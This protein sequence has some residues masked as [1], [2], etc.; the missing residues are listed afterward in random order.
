MTVFV[1]TNGISEALAILKPLPEKLEK[2]AI[3]L[4]SQI[5][6]DDAHRGAGRHNKTGALVQSLFN[7]TIPNGREVGHDPKRAPHAIF[8]HFGTKPHIIQP[9]TKKALRWAGGGKF[10]FAK[11]VKHPGYLGDAY[12]HNAAKAAINQFHTIATQAFNEATR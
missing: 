6:Y 12:L 9:K 8:V 4:M 10:F 1:K 7:R 2:R 11:Q 3:F 5:A